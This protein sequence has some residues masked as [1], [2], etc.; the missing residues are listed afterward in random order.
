MLSPVDS[1]EW[2]EPVLLEG[3]SLLP[4]VRFSCNSM[5]R[6]LFGGVPVLEGGQLSF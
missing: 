3:V 2:F 4:P 1:C 6:G 5:S